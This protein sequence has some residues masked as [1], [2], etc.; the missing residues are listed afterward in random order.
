MDPGRLQCLMK[1]HKGSFKRDYKKK[2]VKNL[3]TFE[4]KTIIKNAIHKLNNLLK[5]IN[6]E[7][8]PLQLYD[9]Y[10]DVQDEEKASDGTW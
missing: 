4:Q 10:N 3:F 8:L 9:Y 2:M 6:R 1:F 7:S 5:K